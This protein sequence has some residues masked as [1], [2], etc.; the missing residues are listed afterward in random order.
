MPG[1]LGSLIN[2]WLLGVLVAAPLALGAVYPWIYGPLLGCVLV[3]AAIW[4]VFI[5]PRQPAPASP[6]LRLSYYCWAA[7]LLVAVAQGAPMP[8]DLVKAISPTAHQLWEKPFDLFKLA[9]PEMAYL[10]LVPQATWLETIKNLA[11]G[12]VF[13]LI[14]GNVCREAPRDKRAGLFC[15]RLI[16]SI[17]IAGFCV[18]LVAIVQIGV[19]AQAIYGFWRPYQTTDFMGTYVNRNHFAGLLEL[20]VPL[21]I[22]LVGVYV[23]QFRRV[24]EGDKKAK[25]RAL[26]NLIGIWTMLIVMFVGFIYSRSRGGVVFG[27]PCIL[28]QV[29]LTSLLV[30]RGR[31]SWLQY[32]V[33]AGVLA[34]T[35][36]AAALIVSPAP[37]VHRLMSFSNLDTQG[38]LRLVTNRDG[39]RMVADFP[40]VGSGLGSFEYVFPVYKTSSAQAIIDHAHN[41]IL[42]MATD[43][44]LV[45]AA[46]WLLLLAVVGVSGVR[47]VWQAIG[48]RASLSRSRQAEAIL[49]LGCLTGFIAMIFHSLVDF[50]LRI[51]ANAL[52][53]Y[54]LGGAIMGIACRATMGPPAPEPEPAP[55]VKRRIRR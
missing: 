7:F 2:W 47:H 53:F 30:K 51:P 36:T 28:G 35:L 45:G 26:F 18:T 19:G 55:R 21:M 3:Q 39:L 16:W 29:V 46:P 37:L 13:T 8:P 48:D 22:G 9:K 4:L 32:G 14:A 15:T 20:T 31:G 43:M 5:K 24:R 6:A 54:A 12:L 1:S 33:V 40:A 44:G 41:D 49:C 50:N 42:E 10:S 17:G 38:D 25:D 11:Y 34:F 52:I 27:L 23:P